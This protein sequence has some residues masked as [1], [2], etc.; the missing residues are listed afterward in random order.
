MKIFMCTRIIII[1]NNTSTRDI[2][3]QAVD[4][5]RLLQAAPILFQCQE[6]KNI[7]L[8]ELRR[9]IDGNTTFN[10]IDD[11]RRERKNARKIRCVPSG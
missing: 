7:V 3:H 6:K 11:Q 8:G 9:F 10:G 1:N 2:R 5:V 4:L